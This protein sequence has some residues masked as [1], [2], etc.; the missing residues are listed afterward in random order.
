MP[1]FGLSLYMSG[2]LQASAH[3]NS[4]WEEEQPTLRKKGEEL[5]SEVKCISIRKTG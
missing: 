2:L 5:L 1:F 4:I 3:S